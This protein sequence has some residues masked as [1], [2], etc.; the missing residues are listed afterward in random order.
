MKLLYIGTDTLHQNISDTFS[1]APGAYEV[2]SAASKDEFIRTL[3]LG[4][5][6]VILYDYCASPADLPLSQVLIYARTYKNP[7]VAITSVAGDAP[8]DDL[9][10][11][12]ISGYTFRE[13]IGQLP[14]VIGSLA[15]N[16][17]LEKESQELYHAVERTGHYYQTLLT[18][19]NDFIFL[20]N[21][22]GDLVYLSPSAHQL[23]GFSEVA[24]RQLF[25]YVHPDDRRQFFFQFKKV[26]KRPDTRVEGHFRIRHK[27]GD[28]VW[29]EGSITNLVKNEAI[30][31]FV[32]SCRD[33]TERTEM[34]QSLLRLNRLYDCIRQINR[35]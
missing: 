11:A 35:A 8:I 28:Y 12:G 29:I 10:S 9:L 26:L 22:K 15:E 16:V 13:H 33:V 30:E 6:G 17:Q 5:V 27:A 3:E 24:G 31:A 4:I 14:F 18:N 1:Q 25:E 23:T 21:E 7:V 2:L 20:F 34:E 32:L 19:I